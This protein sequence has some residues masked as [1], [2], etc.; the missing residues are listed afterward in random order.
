MKRGIHLQKKHIQVVT[1][2]GGSVIYSL[3]QVVKKTKEKKI[4]K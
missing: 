1:K 3:V 4:Q 2:D